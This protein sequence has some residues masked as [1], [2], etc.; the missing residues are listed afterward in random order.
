MSIVE[1]SPQHP[2]ALAPAL[3]SAIAALA[4]QYP[5]ARAACIEALKLVQREYRWVDDQ[6]LQSLAQ[7]LGMT[8]AELDAVATFYNLIYRRPVGRHVI[9][10]CDSISCWLMGA[11]RVREQL[12]AKLGI[13][14]GQTSADGRFT[15]L[16]IVCLGHC[17]HAPALMVDQ[18]LHGDVQSEQLAQLLERYS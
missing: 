17:D 1:S 9:L 3:R 18:D 5:D 4:H 13:E 2:S 15:L 16:P 14:P 6:Q 7:L 12:Q 11:D 10:C 8:A